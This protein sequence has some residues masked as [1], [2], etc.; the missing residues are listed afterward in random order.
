MYFKIFISKSWS[1][2]FT[3]SR[4]RLI[5]SFH[6]KSPRRDTVTV[7]CPL[8]AVNSQIKRGRIKRCC[9]AGAYLL[10]LTAF[11]MISTHWSMPSTPVSRQMS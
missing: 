7:N 9:P 2:R 10:L 5:Q 3:G 8:S 6:N 4:R 11:T 1:E